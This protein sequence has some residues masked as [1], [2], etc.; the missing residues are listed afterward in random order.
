MAATYYGQIHISPHLVKLGEDLTATAATA[1][2]GKVGW[3][4][5][6][7]PVVAGCKGE[8]PTCTWKA[9]EGSDY[10]PSESR[11][12]WSGGWEVYEAGFCGFFGCAPSGDY[13]YVEGHHGCS[14][15]SSSA[16]LAATDE[17]PPLLDLKASAVN[18]HPG[19]GGKLDLTA[20]VI[21]GKE[22]VKNGKIT[23]TLTPSVTLRGN[24]GKGPLKA[25]A[26][27]VPKASSKKVAMPAE[28]APTVVAN[29][30]T[31][32]TMEEWSKGGWRHEPS[33]SATPGGGHLLFSDA[34]EFLASTTTLQTGGAGGDR[35]E[36]V[37]YRETGS[38]LAATAAQP[39]FRLY[40]NHENRT[41]VSKT[42]CFVFT[43]DTA[44]TTISQT[45]AGIAVKLDDPVAAGRVALEAFERSRRG[46]K[47]G[48]A[49]AINQA[50]GYAEC[51]S[52]ATL[53]P[54]SAAKSAEV[55]NGIFDYT[56]SG[57]NVQAGVVILNTSNVGAFLA[58]PLHY[59]FADAAH[60]SGNPARTY[61]SG[62]GLANPK[63]SHVSGTFDYD[64]VKVT[65]PEYDEDAG[66]PVGALLAGDP[67][68]QANQY[69][70]AQDTGVYDKGNFGVF[71]Q[72][73]VATKGEEG[74]AAQVLLNPRAVGTDKQLKV[75]NGFAGVVDAPAGEAGKLG[76]EIAAP[77]HGQPGVGSSGNLTD[78]QYGIGVGRVKAGKRF[79]MEFMP[80]G[81]ASLPV[82]VVL[83]PAYVKAK[84]VLGYDGHKTVVSEP[85]IFPLK[86]AG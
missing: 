82:A 69:L 75:V 19:K 38:T 68:V 44:H 26:G 18:V 31:L 45:H 35:V 62:G 77:A 52:G 3:S 56:A 1:L 54:A 30:H 78:K 81:G 36:G 50:T 39:E 58:D 15:K 61:S 42:I 5:P 76:A 40:I 20:T 12:G 34:P 86:P 70:P 73:Q 2:G 6:P 27:N 32:G 48:P 7:G 4:P 8:E 28:I 13:Y 83:A 16:R 17:C 22:A 66:V 63:E 29:G 21:T 57:G 9:T 47:A 74:E 11:S 37:L 80:P 65:L 33:P 60:T 85:A 14:S 84:G 79:T 43:A 51:P 49:K 67:K 24:A 55:V 46:G 53:K 23:V 64:T 41:S 25:D 10:P 72:V 71:Y 59:K